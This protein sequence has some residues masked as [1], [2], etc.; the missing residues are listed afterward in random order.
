MLVRIAILS[1]IQ[2]ALLAPAA[3]AQTEVIPVAQS[4]QMRR[5]PHLDKLLKDIVSR[6]CT[7]LPKHSPSRVAAT[8][9]DLGYTRKPLLV[10]AFGSWRGD[11]QVYPASVVKI[12]YM[13]AAYVWARQGKLQITPSVYRDLKDM[14]GPSSN[15][16]TQHILN[17]VCGVESGPAL[18]A[19]ELAE[20]ARKRDVVNQWLHGL[21]LTRTNANQATWDENYSPR[22]LQLVTGSVDG[23]GPRINQN[24][25]TSNDVARFLLLIA[26]NALGMPEDCAA[27]RYLMNRKVENRHRP[28]YR[29]IFMDALP[30]G[31][32]CWGKSGFTTETSHDSA[33]IT[34]T[35][36]RRFILVVMAE[37][38]WDNTPF[39]GD[40]AVAV[41]NGLKSI[42][43]MVDEKMETALQMN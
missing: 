27:M 31:T 1:L 43:P 30:A 38:S 28:G 22:D 2:L 19:R 25:S 13:G 10:P 18:S 7:R 41:C 36:G 3:P 5:D 9:V 17:L 14:I 35:D 37:T 34:T 29:V 26:R 21:G 24:Q 6:L 23:Q 11:A 40:F 16:A 20:F 4:T 32:I 39:L 8:L 42:K 15:V 33:I 12:F